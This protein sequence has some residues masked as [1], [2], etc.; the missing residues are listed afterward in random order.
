[1]SLQATYMHDFKNFFI[2]RLDSLP[3]FTSFHEIS[4]RFLNQRC[5]SYSFSE[6]R[7][8]SNLNL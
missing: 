8:G 7:K 6:S 3:L 2:Q 1:M 5:I 4:E